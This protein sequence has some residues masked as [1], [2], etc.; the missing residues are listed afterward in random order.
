MTAIPS[1]DSRLGVQTRGTTKD[2]NLVRASKHVDDVLQPSAD[3]FA[4]SHDYSAAICGVCL[5]HGLTSDLF[6][7]WQPHR[8]IAAKN[9]RTAGENLPRE[10]VWDWLA[11]W[12]G[13][14]ISSRLSFGP[15]G[16]N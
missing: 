14:T 7:P 12:L 3:Q 15:L 4:T 13:G 8:F 9:R 2:G 11:D 5:L 1:T 16:S 6:C 10:G